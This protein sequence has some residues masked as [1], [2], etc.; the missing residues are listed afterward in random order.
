MTITA[1]SVRNQYVAGVSQTIYPYT[2]PILNASELLVYADVTLL[3]LNVHYTVTGIGHSSGG[4]VVFTYPWSPAGHSVTIIGNVPLSQATDFIEHNS[5]PAEAPESALDK[6]TRISQQFQQ[7]IDRA[8]K[9]HPASFLSGVE[10]PQASSIP[11]IANTR[12]AI[13]WN[14]SGTN[15]DLAY[16]STVL[17]PPAT[18]PPAPLPTGNFNILDYGGVGDDLTDNATAI[19]TAIA[20][21]SNGNVLVFPPGR[22]RYTGS[23]TINKMI[24]VQGSSV[25]GCTLIPMTTNA[26]GINITA[27][28]VTVKDLWIER[29]TKPILGGIGLKTPS[30]VVSQIH[31]ERL[32]IKNHYIGVQMGPSDYSTATNCHVLNSETNGWIADYGS[33]AGGAVQWQLTEC[34]SIANLQ[35]GFAFVNNMSALGVGP[36]LDHCT[37]FGNGAGGVL[38]TGDATHS[39]NDVILTQ[40]LSSGDGLSGIKFVDTYGAFHLVEDC[41]IE[42]V[43][44]YGGVGQGFDAVPSVASH[45]G[46]GLAIEGSN[47]GGYGPGAVNVSGGLIATCAWSGAHVSSQGTQLSGI[48]FISNGQGLSGDLSLRA[49]VLVAAPDVGMTG[50]VFT[51]DAGL[52]QSRAIALSGD[53]SGLSV[54]PT[55]IYSGYTDFTAEIIDPSQATTLTTAAPAEPLGARV[56]VVDHFPGANLGARLIAAIAA[57][58][59]A[60]GT[61]DARNYKGAQV[62]TSTIVIGKPC[63]MLFGECTYTSSATPMFQLTAPVSIQGINREQ[64]RFRSTLDTQVVFQVDTPYKCAFSTMA[65][66]HTGPARTG[67]AGISL[68]G[69]LGLANERS[70]M[71][72][73][74]ILDQWVSI[75]ATVAYGWTVFDCYLKNSHSAGILV[76]NT[77]NW[78]EG[79]SVI[80][81]S[82]IEGG[83][84]SATATAILHTSSGGLK[85]IGCKIHGHYHG[86]ALDVGGTTANVLIEGCSF[87]VQLGP[88]IALVRSSGLETFSSVMI[89]GNYIENTLSPC[90]LATTQA[91]SHVIV[92]E[93]ILKFVS[94]NAGV[95]LTSVNVASVFGNILTSNSGTSVG[96]NVEA[97]ALAVNVGHNVY[98]TITTAVVYASA[99]PYTSG[100]VLAVTTTM[101]DALPHIAGFRETV[102][103]T[104]A[105]KFQGW[106]GSAW[107]DFH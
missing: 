74:D 9:L 51:K 88:S 82:K 57:L 17:A 44:E 107:V 62:G 11:T 68:L 2:F 86:Y 40:H 21:M 100:A 106:T 45:A 19:S 58:P 70:V 23:I 59:A 37:S 46:F 73:L 6:L 53:C 30:T 89:H 16:L 4:N 65:I 13:V 66:D 87:K 18:V 83:A 14:E 54:A 41:W 75:F 39:V 22:Y 10:F 92:S 69:G 15:L 50:C 49:G 72:H 102:F 80:L 97:G 93:N 105:G 29:N 25:G 43:G 67:G 94:P 7:A 91:I 99:A 77:V 12:K 35:N 34:T 98:S 8:P 5:F 20:A 33:G 3:L 79:S 52:G 84:N 1:S 101:R 60:G 64:T 27:S 103:N 47:G 76:S 24:T 104:T 38:V 55:N 36:F 78:D 26:T 42:L 32:L 56:F 96:V 85:V 31:L 63:T 95:L 61:I 48:N 71:Q 90:L 81:D 28:F